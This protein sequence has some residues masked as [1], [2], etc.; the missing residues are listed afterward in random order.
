MVG[1][2]LLRGESGQVGDSDKM[3]PF[4]RPNVKHISMETGFSVTVGDTRQLPTQTGLT[5]GDR[6]LLKFQGV[7]GDTELELGSDSHCTSY[8]LCVLVGH[9]S[10]PNL[11][12][13]MLGWYHLYG[14]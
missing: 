2:Q 8:H 11:N 10:S 9:L 7:P 1:S 5:A 3:L 14:W 13:L 6:C 12:F 4:P